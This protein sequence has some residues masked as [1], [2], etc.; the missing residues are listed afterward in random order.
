ML[1]K[2][3]GKVTGTTILGLPPSITEEKAFLWLTEALK[4]EVA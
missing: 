1:L 4:K 2:K 3:L